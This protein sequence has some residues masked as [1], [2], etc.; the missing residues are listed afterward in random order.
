MRF[1]QILLL[2]IACLIVATGCLLL[3]AGCAGREYRSG[4]EAAAW[5]DGLWQGKGRGY[6]GDIQVQV[7]TASGLI[8]EI[9]ITSHNEDLLT[10]GVA[11]EELLELA[12][13]YQSTSLDAVSGA[14]V[15]ST[16]FLSAVNDA[17]NQASG[18]Q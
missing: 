7:R 9:V 12:L 5:Q 3:A 8:Q 1:M 18:Y 6:R 15:S 17:L 11:L 16:G 4:P 14:T 10:G 13:D 2:A